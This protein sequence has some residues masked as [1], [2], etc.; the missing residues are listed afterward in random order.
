MTELSLESLTIDPAMQMRVAGIDPG[1][2]TDYAEAMEDGAEFPPIIV[3]TDGNSYWPADGF[4]RI[5]AARKVGKSSLRADIRQGERRDAILFAAGANSSHG[6]RRSQADKRRSVVSLL[7]DPEWS[8]WSDRQIGKT[9]NVDH[10][11]V[12]R[13]RQELTGEIPSE[14]TYKTKH[15]TVSQMKLPAP[16]AAPEAGTSM[17]DRLLAKASNDALIAECRRRGLEVG[18]E[19]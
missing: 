14:R 13:V 10:K 3:F 16:S 6:V 5:E 7:T 18:H 1:T 15:G 2:V 11:T 4:H 17:V 8:H 12:A 9:C 19:V